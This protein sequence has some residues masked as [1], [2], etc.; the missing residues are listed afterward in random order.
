MKFYDISASTVISAAIL[1]TLF[2]ILAVVISI[3]RAFLFYW[4]GFL[5]VST[6]C[7]ILRLL[8]PITRSVMHKFICCINY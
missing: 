3:L 1:C 6:F 5:A 8:Y 7:L 2:Y 4:I